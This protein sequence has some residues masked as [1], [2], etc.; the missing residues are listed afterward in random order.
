MLFLPR[1]PPISHPVAAAT[2]NTTTKA[3][4]IHKNF[5]LVTVVVKMNADTFPANKTITHQAESFYTL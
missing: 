3:L 5:K 1:Q 2:A 4:N